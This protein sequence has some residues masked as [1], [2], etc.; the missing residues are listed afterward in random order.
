MRDFAHNLILLDIFQ[1]NEGL[2][3]EHDFDRYGIRAQ[4]DF[5]HFS[6]NLL[7]QFTGKNLT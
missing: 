2:N 5:H 6:T 3:L 7:L 1:A 4:Y